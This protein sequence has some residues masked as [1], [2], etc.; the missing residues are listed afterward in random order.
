M[1]FFWFYVGSCHCATKGHILLRRYKLV[2]CAHTVFIPPQ[3]PTS[4]GQNKRQLLAPHKSK[5]ESMR[6]ITL[7]L[8]ITVKCKV[9]MTQGFSSPQEKKIFYW[10]KKQD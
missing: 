7:H 1:K 4:V 6:V 8:D 3:P 2:C 5:G 9:R 10:K